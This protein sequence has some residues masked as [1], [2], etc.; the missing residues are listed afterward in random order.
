MERQCCRLVRIII[1]VFALLLLTRSVPLSKAPRPIAVKETQYV[2]LLPQIRANVPAAKKGIGMP[3]ADCRQL[4]ALGIRWEYNWSGETWN[5]AGVENVP[6]AWAGVPSDVRGNSEWLMGF[7]EPDQP[8]QA[9]LAPGTASAL[10]RAIELRYPG[11]KLVAPAPSHLDPEWL[12]RFRDNYMAVFAKP[13]RMDAL[14]VHCYLPT[15]VECIALVREYETW[16][17]EWN[18]GEI[19]VT[20]FSF[21]DAEQARD[22]ISYLASD[23]LVSRYSWFALWYRGNEVW[24][25]PTEYQAPLVDSQGN[26]TRWGAIYK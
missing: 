20:E 1:L 19:W 25:P 22:F 23:A 17:R 16:A 18:V 7:N 13:P 15:A 3:Y 21:T 9:N 6:M 2:Y 24:S 8:G 11:R 4:A 26:L 12:V 14:A 10:W 5:C